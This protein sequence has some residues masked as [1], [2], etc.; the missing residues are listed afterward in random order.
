LAL[1]ITEAGATSAVQIA[2]CGDTY[3]VRPATFGSQCSAGNTYFKQ[4]SW[5]SW[6]GKTAMAYGTIELPKGNGRTLHYIA[7]AVQVILS[8]PK[9]EKS[10]DV[11]TQLKATYKVGNRTQEYA[12][13]LYL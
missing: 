5:S 3:F 8:L 13:G 1:S 11:Y 4:L 10:H 9:I 2:S 12:F 6:G 7:H